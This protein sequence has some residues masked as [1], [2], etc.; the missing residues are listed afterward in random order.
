MVKGSAVNPERDKKKLDIRWLGPCEIFED[1]IEGR[2]KILH[3]VSGEMDVHMDRLKPYMP[4]MNGDSY[5]LHYFYPPVIPAEKEDP[6]EVDQILGHTRAVDNMGATTWEKQG[7]FIHDCRSYWLAY[8][9]KKVISVSVSRVQSDP[10]P[11]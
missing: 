1:I 5:P 11:P 6:W 4:T 3:P 9:K 10:T 8:N 7:Q 2:Y